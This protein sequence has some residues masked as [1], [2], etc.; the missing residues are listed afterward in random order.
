MLSF[1]ET[2]ALPLDKLELTVLYELKAYY[3]ARQESGRAANVQAA[4]DAYSL[5]KLPTDEPANSEKQE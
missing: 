5:P 4:I 3:V 1:D 2:A